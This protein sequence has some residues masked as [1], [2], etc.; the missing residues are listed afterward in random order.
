M[1]SMENLINANNGLGYNIAQFNE[2]AFIPLTTLANENSPNTNLENDER[3]INQKQE[4][5]NPNFVY[6]LA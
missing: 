2:Q 1:E 4:P 5:N 3:N 6:D